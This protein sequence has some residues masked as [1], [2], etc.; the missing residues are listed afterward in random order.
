MVTAAI[1]P[2][3]YAMIQER[4]RDLEAFSNHFVDQLMA[5]GL[6]YVR[7]WQSRSAVAVGCLAL[8]YLQFVE[9]DSTMLQKTIIEYLLSFWVVDKINMWRDSI[10]LPVPITV[11]QEFLAAAKPMQLTKYDF[12]T[13]KP[14]RPH[15]I[16]VSSTPK[17]RHATEKQQGQV[18]VARTHRQILDDYCP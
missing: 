15:T 2:I 8:V 17:P 5:H 4:E 13:L 1:S 12:V 11:K 14:P 3:F 16:T 10:Y 6:D 18:Q 9:V 7:L